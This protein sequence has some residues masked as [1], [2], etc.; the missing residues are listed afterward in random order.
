M[1]KTERLVYKDQIPM[2]GTEKRPDKEASDKEASDKEASDKE[3]RKRPPWAVGT[4][5]QGTPLP[6]VKPYPNSKK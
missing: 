1:S 6:P 5:D 2:S 3:T 4:A